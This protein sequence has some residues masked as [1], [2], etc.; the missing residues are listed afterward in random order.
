M[1]LRLPRPLSLLPRSH[2][3]LLHLPILTLTPQMGIVHGFFEVVSEPSL[4]CRSVCV[5]RLSTPVYVSAHQTPMGRGC[6]SVMECLA[7][8]W[9][10]QL[11]TAALSLCFAPE[12]E[13]RHRTSECG[14]QSR[15]ERSKRM[16]RERKKY[17]HKLTPAGTPA[18]LGMGFGGGGW[19]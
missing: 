7:D 17:S 11:R 14:F 12:A 18:P 10:T 1:T 3:A 2:E 15:S 4:L 13:I 16:E 9:R 19:G 5:T 8:L 6:S